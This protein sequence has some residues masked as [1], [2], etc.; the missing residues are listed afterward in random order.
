MNKRLLQYPLKDF[1]LSKINNA[2]YVKRSYNKLLLN[3]Y[4]HK[5]HDIIRTIEFSQKRLK[6]N[7]F[8]FIGTLLKDVLEEKFNRDITEITKENV[9]S[10]IYKNTCKKCNKPISDS[11]QFCSNT[12]SNQYK[13]LDPVFRERLSESARSAYEN[14]SSLA[15][16]EKNEKIRKSI[17]KHNA[18]LSNKERKEKYTNKEIQLT[19]FDNLSVRFPTLEFLFNK[20]FYYNNRYLPVMC[21]KC[22]SKFE[23]TKSTTLCRTVCYTCNPRKKHKTQTEIFTWINSLTQSK[24]NIRG[25]INGELDI[26]CPA[27]KMAIEYDGLLP[28]SFGL[29][30]VHYYSN[31]PSEYRLNDYRYH[32]RKTEECEDQGY[33]LLH[34][35]ENEWMDESKRNIWKS[36][37]KSRIGISERIH[38]RKCI[39]KEIDSKTSNTFIERTHLQGVCRSSVKLGLY[40]KGIL[41]S[42]MTF[43]KHRK[44][45]WEIGRF[46]SDLGVNV[47]GGAS[48][49]LK[50]FE[51]NYKPTS[52]VSFANR[53]WSSGRVY[54]KLG[55]EF[56]GNTS[57][58]YFYF[59]PNEN[60]LYPR[61]MFQKHKLKSVLDTYDESKSE[62][63]NMLLNKYR[64]IYDCGHKKYVKK[65]E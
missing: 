52:L 3:Y 48:K 61:E 33:Q 51:T 45:Q 42:V 38:A 53:R 12:C 58:G 10:L 46:S 26:I 16:E 24:E 65:Y 8:K 31:D 18:E 28:H 34:I 5:K 59:L 64:I 11:R 21:K 9:H 25:I 40:H 35:F 43:R 22:G 17:V 44:Y 36:M 62:I 41:V 32:Q 57:P 54:E 29:S 2:A 63:E 39:V 50:Y 4:W 30:K 23:I 6:G 14:M 20:E 7:W 37:I 49:L 13:S 47:V 60:I 19:S 56:H 1:D 27:H 55:F 15:L